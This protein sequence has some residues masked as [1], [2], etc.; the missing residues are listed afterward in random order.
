MRNISCG[1]D[2]SSKLYPGLGCGASFEWLWRYFGGGRRRYDG[3]EIFQQ[4]QDACAIEPRVWRIMI[5]MASQPLTRLTPEEYL[6]LDR[7]SDQKNEFWCG[8]V[9][10]IA[11]GSP[12]HSFVISNV[13]IALGTRFLERD[14]LVFNSDLRVC[15]DASKLW[16][17]P[18]I[19]V[20]CGQPKYTDEKRDTISNPALVVE[21]LSPNTKRFDRGEKLRLYAQCP[22]VRG[23]LLVDPESV[24]VEYSWLLPN[25]HWETAFVSDRTAVVTLSGFDCELPVAEIYRKVELLNRP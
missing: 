9:Y 12:A 15:V 19:T 25:G 3:S 5:A 21:V 11:G 23:I 14:C 8:E 10:A 16:T 13:Q 1:C 18:D 6:A 24:D 7:A 20:V 22:S 2:S 4:P 17:Y